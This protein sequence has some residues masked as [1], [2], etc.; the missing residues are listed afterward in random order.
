MSAV[1]HTLQSI[2][3][4]IE[5]VHV[6]GTLKVFIGSQTISREVILYGTD[7]KHMCRFCNN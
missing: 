4:K 3:N 7:F 6:P 1:R 2:T 5:L